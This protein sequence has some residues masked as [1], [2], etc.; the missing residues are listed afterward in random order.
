MLTDL[1]ASTERAAELGDRAWRDLLA[2]HHALVR[3]ELRRFR[4]EERD[5]AGDGFF[6]TFDGPARAIRAGQAIIAG[7]DTLGLKSRIGVHVGECERH[8]GQLSGIA[9]NIGARIAAAAEA[10]EVIVSSTVRDLVSGSGLTFETEASDSSR[11]FPEPGSSNAATR[12]A[13]G[14]DSRP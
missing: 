14:G 11:A 5:T 3:R 13:P 6:A 12:D 1:V 10:G 9:V 2:Q 7:L 4:G 8:E